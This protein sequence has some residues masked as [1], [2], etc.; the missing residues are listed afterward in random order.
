MDARW[1]ILIATIDIVVVVVLPPTNTLGLTFAALAWLFAAGLSGVPPGRLFRRWLSLLPLIG[2]LTLMV[3]ASHPARPALGFAG[4]ATAL[5][6]K[7]SL[8]VMATV[9]IAEVTPFRKI[10]RA[11]RCMRVPEVLVLTLQF[12]ERYLHVLSEELNRMSHARRA[13]SFRR[14]WRRDWTSLTGLIGVLFLR[15]LERGERVYAAMQ[16]RG[17]DGSFHALDHDPGQ[18]PDRP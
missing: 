17:W 12:M 15:S 13:R 9:L 10:L 18:G 5:L 4:V 1:K 16:A 6:A 8:A 7:S 14:D 3:A 2:F 11:L